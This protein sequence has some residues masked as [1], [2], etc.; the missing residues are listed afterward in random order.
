V[1]ISWPKGEED[2]LGRVADVLLLPGVGQRRVA[3]AQVQAHRDGALNN[4]KLVLGV[5]DDDQW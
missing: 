5:D 1:P 4:M 2:A 3:K